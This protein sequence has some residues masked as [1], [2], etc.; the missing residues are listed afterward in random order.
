MVSCYDH[1]L[2][3][4]RFIIITILGSMSDNVILTVERNGAV[5]GVQISWSVGIYLEGV[6]NGSLTPIVGS[7]MIGPDEDNVILSFTVSH[8][9]IT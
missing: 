2:V 5:G 9:T 4:N 8:M 6:V 3:A 7:V 1:S